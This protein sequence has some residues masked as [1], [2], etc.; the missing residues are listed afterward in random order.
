MANLCVSKAERK[1]WVDFI[2]DDRKLNL[3]TIR[4]FK[5]NKMMLNMGYLI[6]E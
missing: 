4:I 3:T 6:E 1:D 5:I 2:T